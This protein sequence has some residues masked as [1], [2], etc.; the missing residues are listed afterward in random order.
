MGLFL[1]ALAMSFLFPW[2]SDAQIIQA[3]L[4][5][6][7]LSCPFCAFGLE[8]N[9]KKHG[10]GKVET[11]LKTGTL[12]AFQIKKDFEPQTFYKLVRQSGFTL[13]SLHVQA[14]GT[15]SKIQGEWVLM[16]GDNLLFLLDVDEKFNP[17]EN[18]V[19]DVEGNV[20]QSRPVYGKTHPDY[21]Y[22]LTVGKMEK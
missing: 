7:G 14:K 12:K 19:V 20:S 17:S 2:F 5:V 18:E 21:P 4:V 16:D 11:E 8:K 6:K 3:K 15:L 10:V 22:T 9:F 13:K 1:F